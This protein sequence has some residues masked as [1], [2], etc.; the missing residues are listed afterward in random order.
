MSRAQLTSTV[1]QNTGG[2]VAPYVAGKNKIING[3][4]GIW[5][6]GTTFNGVAAAGVNNFSADRFFANRD[7][8][9][10][11]VNLTQQA[12]TPG[13]TI[14]GYE[15]AYY[16]Q[17]AQTVAGSGGTYSNII[18]Q[19]IEDVRTFA[20]QTATFSFWAK[21]D[22]TRNL[23]INFIQY[24]GVG[25][26]GN[27]YPT[28]TTVSVT[29][30]WQR[31]VF[32]VAIP[33]IAGKTIG[34][35]SYLQYVLQSQTNNATQTWSI[36]GMQAEAGSVAT[37]FT[38]ASNTLQGELALCQRYYYRQTP[39]SNY[40]ILAAM[41]APNSTTQALV[42]VVPKVSMRVAPTTLEYGNLEFANYNGTSFSFTS[43]TINTS[44]G[45]GT[46]LIELY[47][48]GSSG[49]TVDRFGYLRCANNATGYLALGAEL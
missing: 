45:G 7:G 33:S 2:A 48:Q 14:P 28:N 9:G 19:N 41:G 6:R 49:L 32:T 31:F 4:F 16:Y 15:S 42:T 3:D 40:G 39:N 8:S 17:Y 10:A 18:A 27:V 25:G 36:W 21:A 29:T 44:P 20:G 37:P 5:A 34:A 11:T 43:L 24:F 30:S 26:S 23:N 38:T 47:L 22:T 1:E 35:G 46:D 13:N 12:F